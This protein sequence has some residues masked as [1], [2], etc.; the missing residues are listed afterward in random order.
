MK[1]R[2]RGVSLSGLILWCFVFALAAITGM[3]LAPALIEYAT[4]VKSAKAV[5]SASSGKTV[6]E[7]RAAFSK[8]LQ[9]DNISVIG[10]ADLDIS[11]EGNDVVLAFAYEKRVPLFA[12]VSLL[13]DFQGSS[14]GRG[15][16]E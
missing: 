9:I 7:I 14:T 16:G 3:K 1:H 11:K 12:N 5:A 2:Q 4:L 13:F 6:P 15:K 8:Y 10:P